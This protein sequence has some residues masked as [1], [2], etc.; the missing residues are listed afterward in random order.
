MR[1][2]TWDV[3][4]DRPGHTVVIRVAQ[5]KLFSEKLASPG[6][7]VFLLGQKSRKK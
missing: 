6:G 4:Q 3:G 1:Q 7:F 5:K 2:F